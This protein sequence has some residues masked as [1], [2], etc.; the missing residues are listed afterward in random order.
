MSKEEREKLR[1]GVADDVLWQRIWD[2]SNEGKCPFKGNR[3][4]SHWDQHCKECDEAEECQ[5]ATQTRVLA[6][7]YGTCL[8]L[9]NESLE[10]DACAQY[11]SP[12]DDG[13][14]FNIYKEGLLDTD[15]FKE[16]RQH[17]REI[18]NYVINE[19]LNPDY[20]LH[21]NTRTY[22]NNCFPEWRKYEWETED[23]LLWGSMQDFYEDERSIAFNW[24]VDHYY[25]P[26]E[27][28]QT[29]IEEETEQTLITS[30]NWR[31][32][33]FDSLFNQDEAIPK[34]VIKKFTQDYFKR[35]RQIIKKEE[36]IAEK[37]GLFGKKKDDDEK[38]PKKWMMS[39]DNP[40][41]KR[42]MESNKG[43]FLIALLNYLETIRMRQQKGEQLAKKLGHGG[44]KYAVVQLDRK[45]A[46]QY[47]SKQDNLENIRVSAH[48]VHR[49][50]K[51][52]TD[53]GMLIKLGKPGPWGNAVYAIGTWF[54]FPDQKTGELVPGGR[55]SFIKK[56]SRQKLQ[57]AVGSQI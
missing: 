7:L 49:F 24:P 18:A 25:E 56:E 29:L 6:I 26:E 28:E 15:W 38:W 55:A 16:K 32:F 39:K 30:G 22:F 46:A 34:K 36:Q 19:N 23:R 2:N 31:G 44:K 42:F 27:M 11:C 5:R 12:Y 53:H 33:P 14:Y 17:I 1:R 43:K 51:W 20:Y 13:E 57:K 52:M 47:L 10:C 3:G 4:F 41:I 45:Q 40:R 37:R 48:K 50:I 54:S 21:P 35:Q 9:R 8:K